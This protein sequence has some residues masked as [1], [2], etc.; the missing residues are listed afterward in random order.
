M[1]YTDKY[2]DQ[3]HEKTYANKKSVEA[4]KVCGCFHCEAI[5]PA[6]I[7]DEELDYCIDVPDMTACCH[8]CGIDSVICDAMDVEVTKELLAAMRKRYFA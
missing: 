2:L 7:I 1:K 3:L 5:Y 4:S 8:F 6:D